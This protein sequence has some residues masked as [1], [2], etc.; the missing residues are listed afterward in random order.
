MRRLTLIS[1]GILAA[2][3]TV[4]VAQNELHHFDGTIEFVS[5]GTNAV[6]AKTLLQRLPADQICGADSITDSTLFLQD[7]DFNTPET[8]AIEVRG[9]NAAGPATG[10]PD[11]S[12]GGL[13]GTTGPIPITFPMPTTG[14]ASA[15]IVTIT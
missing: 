14:V 12:A 6:N 13:I 5:R 11:M 1:A 10:S 3:A 15:V 7:Q 4:A 8:F 9:N 2:T